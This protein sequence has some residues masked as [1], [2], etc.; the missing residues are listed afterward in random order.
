MTLA[1]PAYAQALLDDP[2]TLHIANDTSGGPG[3]SPNLIASGNQ[4]FID[5]VSD[6]NPDVIASPLFVIFAVPDFLGAP[7]ISG[8]T[9]KNGDPN[10]TFNDFA[11]LGDFTGGKLVPF[12]GSHPDTADP[13]FDTLFN[14]VNFNSSIQFSSMVTEEAADENPSLGPI[15]GFNIYI[16]NINQGL[17]GQD[18]MEVQGIFP[19]GT[20][21]V[22][23]GFDATDS[24]GYST[25]DTNYGLVTAQQDA[26]PEPRTWVMML[27]GFGMLGFAAMRKGKRE[28]RLAV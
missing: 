23:F 25:S 9:D 2:T 13:N 10:I 27:A 19:R 1:A 18:W 21:I 14:N 26:V 15:T 24:K 28:A 16:E 6:G 5:Q 7:S 17:T 11:F 3:T 4:F 22:P 12:I 20:F 8:V